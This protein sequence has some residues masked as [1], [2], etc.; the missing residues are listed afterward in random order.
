[1]GSGPPPGARSDQGT[2]G[3][4]GYDGHTGIIH[5]PFH[6]ESFYVTTKKAQGKGQEQGA[7]DP[8]RV[9]STEHVQVDLISEFRGTHMNRSLSGT[10]RASQGGFRTRAPICADIY[11]T[12]MPISVLFTSQP[13]CFID[14]DIRHLGASTWPSGMLGSPGSSI[15]KS[16]WIGRELLKDWSPWIFADRTGQI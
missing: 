4:R 16:N 5:K 2:T 1:M 9:T 7:P 15:L 8:R 11:S 6:R 13:R 12:Y 10:N 3:H 14:R